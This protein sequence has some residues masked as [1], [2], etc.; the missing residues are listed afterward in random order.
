M[1]KAVNYETKNL[2][3]C[4]LARRNNQTMIRCTSFLDTLGLTFR[5]KYSVRLT[6]QCPVVWWT[7]AICS[8]LSESAAALQT[9]WL[10]CSCPFAILSHFWGTRVSASA[11]LQPGVIKITFNSSWYSSINGFSVLRR[12]RISISLDALVFTCAFP[13]NVSEI[14]WYTVNESVCRW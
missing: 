9:S 7:W 4:S 14:Q 8:A 11:R 2:Y 3:D 13:V 1:I 12:L 10:G 6:P 5:T